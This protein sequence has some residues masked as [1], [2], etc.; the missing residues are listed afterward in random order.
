MGDFQRNSANNARQY[1]QKL[2]QR[3]R[4]NATNKSHPRFQ[5]QHQ[6]IAAESI[7]SIDYIFLSLENICNNTK[8]IYQLKAYTSIF[9]C[10][11]RIRIVH[12][13]VIYT[14]HCRAQFFV[15]LLMAI[16]SFTAYNFSPNNP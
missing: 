10:I 11:S 13:V 2:K 1:E 9:R 3:T 16:N 15:C 8:T 7:A 4:M 12:L 14:I 5:Q 6:Q